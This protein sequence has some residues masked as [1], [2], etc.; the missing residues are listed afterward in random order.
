M[1]RGDIM[2]TECQPLIE[3]L[4]KI[5]DFRKEKGKRHPLPSVL[6]LA[7]VA[8]MCGAKEPALAKARVTVLSLNGV[9][10]MVKKYLKLFY[11]QK[12]TLCCNLL[13]YIP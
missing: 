11:I 10:T 6:A 13:Q 12:N 8:M 3:I 1:R 2:E 4:S 9:V 5:P 7:C